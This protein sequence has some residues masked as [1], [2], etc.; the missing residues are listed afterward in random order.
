MTWELI[1]HLGVATCLLIGA[2]FTLVAGIGLLKLN[3][4]MPRLHAPTKVGTL[5]VGA[6]LLASMIHSFILGESSFHELL[7][8]TFLF[9]TAPISANFI[10][11]VNI[12]ERA[13]LMPPAPPKDRSWSTL[14]QATDENAKVSLPD[15]A[16]ETPASS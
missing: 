7:I 6:M 13:C 10:S 4:P 14:A 2:F 12:H 11:K 9:V 1:G 15:S 16:K 8:L 5:G 3:G